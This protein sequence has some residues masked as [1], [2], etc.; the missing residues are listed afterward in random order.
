MKPPV[1][2]VQPGDEG[3]DDAGGQ[4][5]AQGGGQSAGKAGDLDAHE[6]R[7]IDGDG[8]RRHLG[9]GDEIREFAHGKPAVGVHHLSLNQRHGRVAAAEA[10]KAD[11]QKTQ[12]E[13]QINHFRSS[14]LIWIRVR[15]VPSRMQARTM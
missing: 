6:G 4:D 3:D 14:L 1:P 5:A 11:L 8:A 7:G 15:A 13:L 2:Q 12:E 9:N 10:E